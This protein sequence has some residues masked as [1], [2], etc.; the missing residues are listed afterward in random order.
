MVLKTKILQ[1]P[2]FKARGDEIFLK[3]LYAEQEK[4]DKFGYP[5]DPE[6][7]HERV[8]NTHRQRILRSSLDELKSEFIKLNLKW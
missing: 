1:S 6:E 8:K 7:L 2:E 5:V 4:V 3:V